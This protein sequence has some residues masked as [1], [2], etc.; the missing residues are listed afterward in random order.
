MFCMC[1]ERVSIIFNLIMSVLMFMLFTIAVLIRLEP[2]A[3]VA[4]AAL[5]FIPVSQLGNEYK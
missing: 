5:V 3:L 1:I 2:E 4:M